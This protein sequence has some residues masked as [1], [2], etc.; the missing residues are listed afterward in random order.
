MKSLNNAAR[1]G[2]VKISDR[3]IVSDQREDRKMYVRENGGNYDILSSPV[4]LKEYFRKLGR[5]FQIPLI[6]AITIIDAYQWW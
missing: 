6:N 4:D 5:R 1:I 3:F 2:L